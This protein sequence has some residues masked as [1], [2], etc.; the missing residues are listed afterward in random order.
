MGAE[1]CEDIA[2]RTYRL[3]EYEGSKL[4][5]VREVQCCERY[6]GE[7]RT[8]FECDVTKDGKKSKVKGTHAGKP[9]DAPLGGP[10]NTQDFMNAVK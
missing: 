2:L 10:T 1:C 8:D 6:N 7:G 4:V 5:T 3:E 9:S